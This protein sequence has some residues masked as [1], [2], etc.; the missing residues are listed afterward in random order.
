M[1]WSSSDAPY[2]GK[3]RVTFE[4]AVFEAQWWTLDEPAMRTS[5]R[6]NMSN[7][8]PLGGYGKEWQCV[9]EFDPSQGAYCPPPLNRAASEANLSQEISPPGTARRL[10]LE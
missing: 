1:G 4:G 7:T 5:D 3:D 9:C 8:G 6:P 2:L 10:F